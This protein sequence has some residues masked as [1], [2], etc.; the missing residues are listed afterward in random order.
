MKRLVLALLLFTFIV[1]PSFSISVSNNTYLNIENEDNLTMDTLWAKNG[2]YEE[3]VIA[4]GSKLLYE[5]K[6]NKRVPFLV[7]RDKTINATSHRFSKNVTIHQGIL[8][9]VDNDDELAFII[10][11]EI[12]HSLDAY[13]GVPAWIANNFNSK[14]YEYKSDLMGIDMMVK[15]GYNPVAA[16]TCANKFMPE[17]QWDFG[18]FF[19]HPKTSKRLMEMYKYIRVKYPWALNTQMASNIHYVNFTRCMERDI[20]V[21]EQKRQEKDYKRQQKENAKEKV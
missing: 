2:K 9:Y 4:V 3:K 11:H 5:N 19:S 20:K 7:A 1:E 16:L 21:F 12:S 15:A 14:H 6:I 8:P 18:F 10:G 13:G 17:D